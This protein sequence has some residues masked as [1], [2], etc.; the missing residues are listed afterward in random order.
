MVLL[1]IRH[2]TV[3]AGEK[4]ARAILA[5]YLE[6]HKLVAAGPLRIR[7]LVEME[8]LPKDPGELE[9]EI[10]FEQPIQP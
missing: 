2:T 7:P 5:R 4:S 3:G 9:V 8:R 6:K 10:Q 1:R